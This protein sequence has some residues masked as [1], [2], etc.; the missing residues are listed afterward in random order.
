[1]ANELWIY[2]VI[3]EDFFG[4]GVTP[5]SV[6][7]QMKSMDKAEPLLVRI[8]SPGGSVFDGVAIKTLIDEWQAGVQ[9]QVDGIAASA[10][11]YIAMA[12]STISMA[13]GSM[14]MIHNPWSV[15]VGNAADMR[16]EAELLDKVGD[17][18]AA[19]YATKSG[20]DIDVIKAALDAETWYTADE[21]VAAGL[22][23]AVLLSPAEAYT[24]PPTMGYRNIPKQPQENPRDRVGALKRKL[25]LTRSQFRVQ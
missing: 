20:A 10:A 4:E 8:N 7:D 2:D 15:V 9:V 11:S 12:G 23:D 21:A 14:L 3:G 25:T 1:M 5:K 19:A 16:K 13:N 24:I 18:L 22:A 17:Q 6:R